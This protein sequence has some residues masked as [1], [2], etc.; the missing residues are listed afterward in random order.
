MRPTILATA[1][2]LALLTASPA[3]A[4]I[5]A[6]VH[7]DIP[8]GHRQSDVVYRP[9]AAPREVR[10]DEYDR[11]GDGDW[12]RGDA[13]RGWSPVT[14]YYFAGRYYERPFRGA[15]AIVIYRYRGRYFFPPRDVRWEQRY[16]RDRDWGRSDNRDRDDR[17]Q[18]NRDDRG[19]NHRDDRGQYNRDDRGANHRDDR[20]GSSH[21]DRG[22][23]SND[24]ATPPVPNVRGGRSRPGGS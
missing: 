22:Q 5:T 17:G 6:H 16:G 8:I 3:G 14:V 20:G 23:G 15:R 13:Y 4:Q 19:P 10:I 21:A 9:E 18:Y 1:P 11:R 2:L 24:R 7:I 12:D